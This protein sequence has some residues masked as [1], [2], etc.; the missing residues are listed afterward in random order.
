M[1]MIKVMKLVGYI[2]DLR[3][4]NGISAISRLESRRGREL[5]P[6]PLAPQAKSLTT[7]LPSLPRSR[8]HRPFVLFANITLVEYAGQ[9]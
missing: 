2:E 4:F 8:S 6:G 3:R 5:T 9:I 1:V 7:R